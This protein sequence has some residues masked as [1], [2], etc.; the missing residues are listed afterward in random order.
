MPADIKNLHLA[1]ST[2]II[3]VVSLTYGM[4]PTTTLPLLF[5]FKVE[6]T[7]L[8]QVFRATMG[9]YIGM[10]ALWLTGIARP[11]FWRTATIS[12]I[13]FMMGLAV[14]RLISLFIDGFHSKIFLAG[15]ALEATLAF[16]G[17]RNLNKY[18]AIGDQ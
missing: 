12:N 6:S 14:G 10:S 13:F 11:L 16:W 7:D 8:K 3:V 9:L 5:D 4:V 2:M 18:Q 15:L 17:L 1:I